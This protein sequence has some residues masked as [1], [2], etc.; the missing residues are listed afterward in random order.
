SLE[1]ERRTN[2][3]VSTFRN[4]IGDRGGNS[5]SSAPPPTNNSHQQQQ[6]ANNGG[7]RFQHQQQQQQ[8]SY[9]HNRA[10]GGGNVSAAQRASNTIGNTMANRVQ[11]F[12]GDPNHPL[13]NFREV[14][15]VANTAPE[16]DNNGGNYG[17]SAS[18]YDSR[19]FSFVDEDHDTDYERDSIN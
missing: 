10:N 4:V 7:P 16:D 12:L 13:R 18:S 11:N 14:G 2:K 8:N 15:R 19:S 17:S 3:G 5:S 9:L 6:H 1:E